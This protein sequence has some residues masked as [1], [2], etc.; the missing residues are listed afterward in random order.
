MWLL[1]SLLLALFVPQISYVINPIGGLAAILMFVFPG[2]HAFYK[3]AYV[4]TT[5]EHTFSNELAPLDSGQE[6]FSERQ[7]TV[8]SL[9]E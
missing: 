2:N 3:Q 6:T 7:K 1:L 8:H 9:S 4:F 5:C